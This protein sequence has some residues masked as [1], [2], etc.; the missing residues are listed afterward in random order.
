VIVRRVPL[1]YTKAFREQDG[2]HGAFE[3]EVRAAGMTPSVRTDV[4]QTTGG[5]VI[6]ERVMS[7]DGVVVQ[8]A[9]TVIPGAVALLIPLLK[10]EDT[11]AGGLMSRLAD[12]GHAAVSFTETITVRT[13]TVREAL[14][15]GLDLPA[16]EITHI[17]YNSMGTPVEETVCLLPCSRWV[18]DYTW[19]SA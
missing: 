3:A 11:G 16:Y 15:L 9:T 17:A 7:A 1:R 8:L 6:R 2:A 19:H 13:A 18:L 4:S 10:Y 12:A 14:L 5:E